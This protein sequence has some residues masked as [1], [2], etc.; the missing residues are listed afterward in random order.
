MNPIRDKLKRMKESTVYRGSLLTETPPFKE[1]SETENTAS[2]QIDSSCQDLKETRTDNSFRKISLL[3][4]RS[5]RKANS[6]SFYR[7]EYARRKDNYEH[8][9][10]EEEEDHEVKMEGKEQLLMERI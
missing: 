9:L 8:S 10:L 2:G 7:K 1:I 3:E 4:R 6:I 5:Q